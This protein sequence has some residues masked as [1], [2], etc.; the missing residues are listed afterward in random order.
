MFISLREFFAM[1]DYDEMN[2]NIILES[3]QCILKCKFLVICNNHES[4]IIMNGVL[5]LLRLKT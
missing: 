5:S 2:Y 3:L 4:H 1:L